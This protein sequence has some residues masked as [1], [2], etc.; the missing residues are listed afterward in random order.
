[1]SNIFNKFKEGLSKSSKK[2]S[3][4]LNKLVKKKK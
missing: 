4:E 2:I 1:M 3:L